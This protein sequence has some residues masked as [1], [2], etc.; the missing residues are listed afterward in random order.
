LNELTVITKIDKDE[1]NPFDDGWKGYKT[2]NS[3]LKGLIR[4]W[5][6]LGKDKTVGQLTSTSKFVF[7]NLYY[8]KILIHKSY[9][10]LNERQ[11]KINDLLKEDE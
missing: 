11:E 3:I 2:S 10:D 6:S 1:S 8:N 7:N 5:E 9:F 4:N